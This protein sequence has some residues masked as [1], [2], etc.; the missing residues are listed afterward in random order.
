MKNDDMLLL[1]RTADQMGS[2]LGENVIVLHINHCMENSFEFSRILSK[3]FKK[4]LFIGAPYNDRKVPV[5]DS[6]DGYYAQPSQ[7]GHSLY[8]RD[9]KLCDVEGS[10]VE[11]V[12]ALIE[13]SVEIPVRYSQ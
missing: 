2:A 7:G 6:F 5:E 1:S 9:K 13:K 4:V 8:R 10:F 12:R 3:V 11:V